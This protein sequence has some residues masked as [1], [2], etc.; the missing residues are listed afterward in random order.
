MALYV[1]GVLCRK[2]EGISFE[3]GK[4]KIEKFRCLMKEFG[5]CQMDNEKRFEQENDLIK[6]SSLRE[7][8]W[9]LWAEWIYFGGG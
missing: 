6:M 4:Q 5:L 2:E 3:G 9:S 7:L 8:I 1:A